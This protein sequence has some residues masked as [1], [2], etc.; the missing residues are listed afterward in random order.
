MRQAALWVA[1]PQPMLQTQVPQVAP[2]AQKQR[3]QGSKPGRRTARVGGEMAGVCACNRLWRV[4]PLACWPAALAQ[5]PKGHALRSSNEVGAAPQQQR[6]KRA[7]QHSAGT[8]KN[9]LHGQGVL[10]NG[11]VCSRAGFTSC[12]R[13]LKPC[14]QRP[15]ACRLCP[16]Q[17]QPCLLW[18]F[19]RQRLFLPWP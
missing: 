16:W 13:V 1:P 12:Q 4:P 2:P 15:W 8:N 19:W 17:Q 9:A 5:R 18:P 7:T 14:Q 3:Q 11:C 10:L 6:C